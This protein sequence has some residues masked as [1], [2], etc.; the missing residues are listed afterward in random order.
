M[1][2]AQARMIAA[3]INRWLGVDGRAYRNNGG[4]YDVIAAR[5]DPAN[6]GQTIRTCLT[7]FN[8]GCRWI[9]DYASTRTDPAAI[10]PTPTFCRRCGCVISHAYDYCSTCDSSAYPQDIGAD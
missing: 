4:T 3:E 5:P 6:A 9:T 1:T 10:F 2:A 8:E 7:T